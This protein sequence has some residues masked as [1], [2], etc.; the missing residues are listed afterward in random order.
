MRLIN[1]DPIN[2]LF[3]NSCVICVYFIYIIYYLTD[4]LK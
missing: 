1:S 4:N 2:K 3:I